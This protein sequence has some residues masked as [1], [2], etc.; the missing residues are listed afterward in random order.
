ML[1]A[2]NDKI[3]LNTIMSRLRWNMSSWVQTLLLQDL[4]SEINTQF[5]G[6]GRDHHTGNGL[7]A[8]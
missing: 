3:D 4:L 1:G 6:I 2:L 5:D 7:I 8:R